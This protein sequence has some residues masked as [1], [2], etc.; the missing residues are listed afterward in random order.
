MLY[1]EEI[2]QTINKAGFQV[3]EFKNFIRKIHKIWNSLKDVL[4]DMYRLM[5]DLIRKVIKTVGKMCSAIRVNP[6][7]IETLIKNLQPKQRYKVVRKLGEKEYQRFFQ[8]RHVYRI[9]S[10]C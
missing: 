8:R 9:R 2:K 10:C 7:T 1:T 3:A 6:E 4:S 5:G